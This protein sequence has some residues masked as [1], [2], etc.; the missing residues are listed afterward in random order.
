MFIPDFNKIN[1][2]YIVDVILDNSVVCSFEGESLEE[3]VSTYMLFEEEF[4]DFKFTKKEKELR[5]ENA[6]LIIKLKETNDLTLFNLLVEVNKDL[7]AS[8]INS[9]FDRVRREAALN[10]FIEESD[11]EEGGDINDLN[12]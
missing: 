8:Y 11:E 7:Q 10:Y 1:Q 5:L 2:N 3:V 9:G 12:I 4:F 6:K